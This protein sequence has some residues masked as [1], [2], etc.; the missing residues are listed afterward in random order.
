MEFS[1]CRTLSTFN[2]ILKLNEIRRGK[3]KAFRNNAEIIFVFF[4][5]KRSDIRTERCYFLLIELEINGLI[6]LT[7]IVQCF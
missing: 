3:F 5:I 6:R 2:E 4:F 7:V 1:S